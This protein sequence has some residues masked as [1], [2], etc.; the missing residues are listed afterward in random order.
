[1]AY[2][3]D[4]DFISDERS[5]S[6]WQYGSGQPIRH[7]EVHEEIEEQFANPEDVH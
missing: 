6:S 2:T 7:W 5:Y 3:S 1:M 4:P